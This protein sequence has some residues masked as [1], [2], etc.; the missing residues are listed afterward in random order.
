M[1]F[2]EVLYELLVQSSMF[3]VFFKILKHSLNQSNQE[4]F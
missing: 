4:L 1:S 3:K 2:W